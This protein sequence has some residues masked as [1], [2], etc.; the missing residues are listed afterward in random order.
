MDDSDLTRLIGLNPDIRDHRYKAR[1]AFERL[2]ADGV[3]DL[4]M[5]RKEYR[6]FGPRKKPR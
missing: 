5:D 6:I 4:R 3:I 2:H 1:K